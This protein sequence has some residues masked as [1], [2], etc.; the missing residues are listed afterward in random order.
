MRT[1]ARV[2]SCNIRDEDMDVNVDH[3]TKRKATI[4]FKTKYPVHMTLSDHDVLYARK[5]KVRTDASINTN[6]LGGSS[7][8]A[9]SASSPTTLI[10]DTTGELERQN[11][12]V[13]Y[14]DHEGVE[15]GEEIKR[16]AEGLLGRGGWRGRVDVGF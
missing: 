15:F 1:K 4:Q 3:S 12:E 7:S 16:L 11:R 14:R 5:G 13:G 6:K 8:A 9:P 2:R 10:V